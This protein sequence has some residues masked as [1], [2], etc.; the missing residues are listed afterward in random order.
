MKKYFSVFTGELYELDEKYTLHLDCGQL[1]ITNDP[2]TNCK[3]CY[4]RGYTNKNVKTGH[5][6]LCPCCLKDADDTF[7]ENVAQK[8][9]QDVTLHTKKSDFD[10]IVD[11]IYS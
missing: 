2:K 10:S 9:I 4:G 8:E 1:E 3:K 5:Y 6:S 7:F 11:D